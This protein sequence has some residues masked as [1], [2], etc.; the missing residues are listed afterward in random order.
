M[1]G[2]PAAVTRRRSWRGRCA[3]G[4]GGRCRR[5]AAQRAGR[6][7]EGG[8]LAIFTWACRAVCRGRRGQLGQRGGGDRVPGSTSR[9][10]V[11]EPRFVRRLLE[12]NVPL[13]AR[14]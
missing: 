3:A 14:N 7:R 11:V 9:G 1:S 10:E 5:A 4:V 2:R 13:G 12:G 6:Q 8:S